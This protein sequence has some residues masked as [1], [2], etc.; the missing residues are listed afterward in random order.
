[1]VLY[2]KDVDK[3]QIDLKFSNDF[4][5]MTINAPQKILMHVHLSKNIDPTQS[6]FSVTPKKIEIKM[7]K[8]EEGQWS[9]F[10]EHP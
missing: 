10:E 9:S 8:Q 3:S 7:K 4:F 6:S 1:M 5:D 2:I